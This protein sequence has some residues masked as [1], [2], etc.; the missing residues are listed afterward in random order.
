VSFWI[1]LQKKLPG[2]LKKASDKV[3][4]DYAR[5]SLPERNAYRDDPKRKFVRKR[6]E[7][8]NASL[9][10]HLGYI[11]GFVGEFRTK[12]LR[13]NKKV[14]LL[15][16]FEV[17]LFRERST[18]Q[19]VLFTWPSGWNTNRRT[20]T[21]RLCSDEHRKWIHANFRNAKRTFT[22]EYVFVSCY[23]T[24]NIPLDYN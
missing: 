21:K 18:Q 1:T 23:E 4:R 14:G 22:R 9:Y 8:V 3:Y 6:N 2:K 16:K 24:H 7:K 15:L 19:P 12:N 11:F 17:F 13:P 10:Y 20:W 5:D